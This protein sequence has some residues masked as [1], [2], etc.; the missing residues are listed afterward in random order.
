MP[1]HFSTGCGLPRTHCPIF[2][3]RVSTVTHCLPLRRNWHRIQ[4]HRSMHAE[5]RFRVDARAI[6]NGDHS[7][8]RFG[9][10][11]GIRFPHPRRRSAG[12]HGP[13][14][15]SPWLEQRFFSISCLAGRSLSQ[16][17]ILPTV[18]PSLRS[19]VK[20]WK[21]IKTSSS[22]ALILLALATNFPLGG[23]SVSLSKMQGIARA[24]PGL[25]AP[26]TIRGA[27][28]PVLMAA[29]R[30]H[31]FEKEEGKEAFLE[32]IRAAFL[33]RRFSDLDGDVQQGFGAYAARAERYFADDTSQ[34]PID[35]RPIESLAAYA[36]VFKRRID[37]TYVSGAGVSQA[38]DSLRFVDEI[39]AKLLELRSM[40]SKARPAFAAIGICSRR[41]FTRSGRWPAAIWTPSSM[42][43]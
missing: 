23:H 40:A 35:I 41:D 2:C 5:K 13:S 29:G 16:P 19:S 10:L 31:D 4:R 14:R 11:P 15:R 26:I 9:A 25:S 20:C 12:Q 37:N 6:S 1:F 30:K 27:T 8:A 33:D 7:V 24:I 34:F 32:K 36:G 38:K 39:Q 28:L 42:S 21:S 17:V 3:R 43:R 22:N 18:R